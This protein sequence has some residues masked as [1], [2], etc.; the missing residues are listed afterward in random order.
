MRFERKD[1]YY[2]KPHY[3][4]LGEIAFF[5]CSNNRL[6]T[7][8]L[9]D[10]TKSYT[11]KKGKDWLVFA[12]FIRSNETIDDEIGKKSVSVQKPNNY[13]ANKKANPP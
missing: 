13:R 10:T 8:E 1:H 9:I 4:C 3:F 12:H 11:I 2:K 7:Y 6:E 5:S